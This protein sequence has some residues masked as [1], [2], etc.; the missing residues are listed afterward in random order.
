MNNRLSCQEKLNFI[1]S[2]IHNLTVLSESYEEVEAIAAKQNGIS[3]EDLIENNYNPFT[4]E[5]HANYQTAFIEKVEKYKIGPGK[6]KKFFALQCFLENNFVK[7]F[8]KDRY[9]YICGNAVF[10]DNSKKS[11]TKNG[12]I[13]HLQHEC[14]AIF[15]P[16]KIDGDKWEPF[17]QLFSGKKRLIPK[18]DDSPLFIN[19][20]NN[21]S[22]QNP[23][24][25]I[26]DQR[27]LKLHGSKIGAIDKIEE[28]ISKKTGNHGEDIFCT[29]AFYRFIELL[30]PLEIEAIKH[31]IN[32]ISGFKKNAELIKKYRVNIQD[33][34]D[35][36]ISEKN[37]DESL[38]AIN[39]LV[40]FLKYLGVKTSITYAVPQTLFQEI[41]PEHDGSISSSNDDF[42]ALLFLNFEKTMDELT[43]S[44]EDKILE[45]LD[46]F[47]LLTTPSIAK[48]YKKVIQERI[49]EKSIQSA[50]STIM[51][52]NGS[53]NIGSHVLSAVSSSTIDISD[54]QV[55]FKYIQQRMDFIAQIT[56]EIPNWSHST[57]FVED[58]MRRF[59][60]QRHLL[61]YIV[62]SEGLA[63]YEYRDLD[64]NEIDLSCQKKKLIIKIRDAQ[65]KPDEFIIAPGSEEK[66]ENS[67]DTP[68]VAIPGGLIGQHAFFTILE[69]IIRNSAKHGWNAA[70]PASENLE[71]TIEYENKPGKDYV[72]FRIW[73][74]T[75][76]VFKETN[77][78]DRDKEEISTQ[79]LPDDKSSRCKAESED[80]PLHQKLN[81]RLSRS[82]IRQN[83]RNIGELIKENWGLAEMKI[84]AGFLN[85]NSVTEIGKEGAGVL[86]N[87][88]PDNTYEGFI[89]AIGRKE[90]TQDNCYRLCYEFAVPKPKELLIIGNQECLND[91][92]KLKENGIFYTKKRPE[93]MDFDFVM[94]ANG[95]ICND[96]E[97][98]F[99]RTQY[100]HRIFCCCSNESECREAGVVPVEMD[101]VQHYLDH[102]DE[103]NNLD[104]LKL[105]L[106]KEFIKSRYAPNDQDISLYVE[107]RPGSNPGGDTGKSALKIFLSYFKK[108]I[109]DDF[110]IIDNS[111]DTYKMI[112]D[113]SEIA[114]DFKALLIKLNKKDPIFKQNATKDLK[115]EYKNYESAIKKLMIKYD[116]RIETLPQYYTSKPETKE[117]PGEQKEDGWNS[118]QFC[119]HVKI[120]KDENEAVVK[121]KRHG[122][123][124][125][126]PAQLIYHEALSGAQFYFSR[127]ENPAPDGSYQKKKL[128]FQMIENAFAKILIIDERIANYYHRECSRVIKNR[129]DYRFSRICIPSRIK[130][131]EKHHDIISLDNP[132]GDNNDSGAEIDFDGTTKEFN[133]IIIHQGVLD[134]KIRLERGELLQGFISALEEK[135]DMLVITSGR[136]QPQNKETAKLKFLSYSNLESYIK[137]PY[138]EKMLLLQILHQLSR[139]E[140]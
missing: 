113:Y 126:E 81:C 70:N 108:Q 64:N 13:P 74:N 86:F 77:I 115:K 128:V 24:I 137:K 78:E 2:W 23:E 28:L 88:K 69:N 4:T 53:H 45:L 87:E 57:L 63:A 127:L 99:N 121:Y 47:R 118:V 35:F 49:I 22:T 1:K 94:F 48:G 91:Y 73:D 66:V 71:I 10:I 114:V 133:F 89:K 132:T 8:L 67:G 120:V 30:I 55:L 32:V 104:D 123:P 9:G 17:M 105:Y 7:Q 5:N 138:H 42:Y 125:E 31:H 19:D 33:L 80:L 60:M 135:C 97:F 40:K 129:L 37:T 79:S 92:Q 140:R 76:D 3:A 62:R 72:V 139:V 93:T 34:R 54:D 41:D 100:P 106:Y 59:F 90:P 29:E 117:N 26:R 68:R 56:T 116:E 131:Q 43:A 18:E 102:L 11:K 65:A 110:S 52:R 85:K 136:G 130:Y 20:C 84:S 109:F 101:K 50:I 134:N 107:P 58:L 38:K 83:P 124:I 27:F 21:S 122:E 112:K 119:D 14:E 16:L 103:G 6:K 12:Y 51:S 36:S 111:G 96:P 98:D 61:H 82:F 39:N 44:D 15:L 75:S 46:L 95:Q 25:N